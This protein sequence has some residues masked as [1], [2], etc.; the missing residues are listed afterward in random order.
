MILVIGGVGVRNGMV[1]V[2]GC[3]DVEHLVLI[4]A[5]RVSGP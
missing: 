2:M 4:S 5:R 3:S 1:C